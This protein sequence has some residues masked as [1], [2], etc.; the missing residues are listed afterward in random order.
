MEPNKAFRAFKFRKTHG[1]KDVALFRIIGC[2]LC[3]F[4]TSGR[5]KLRTLE[6]FTCNNCNERPRWNVIHSSDE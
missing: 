2:P 1:D 5:M 4:V 3:G 6:I